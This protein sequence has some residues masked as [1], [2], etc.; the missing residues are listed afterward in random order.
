MNSVPGAAT[1]IAALSNVSVI[2]VDTLQ[3]GNIGS[4]ARALKN[5]GLGRLKLVNPP[6]VNEECR[7]MAGKAMDL[8]EG[9]EH[10][11]SLEDA[12]AGEAVVAATTSS[13][14]RRIRRV[15]LTPRQAAPILLGHAQ[16][17]R[18]AIVFGSE[19]SGLNEDQLA[20]C[21]V[22]ITIPANP[23][24]PVLNLAQSV[25]LLAYELGSFVQETVDPPLPAA[26]QSARQE[27]FEQIRRT[28]IEIG[29][30]SASNPEPVLRSI[31]AILDQPGLTP[32]DV[33]IIRGIMSQM[34]WYVKDGWR[35]GPEGVRK[36]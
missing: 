28:L 25:L 15:P 18:V 21:Q 13:R 10:F 6:P 30:L 34:D 4:A 14:D 19:R 35:L 23:E 7:R 26:S 33:R 11:P 29:F 22:L 5:M 2:L 3:A 36:A 12:V 16:T 31:R 9:A 17:E 1:K 24:Y 8:I 27:M 20:Q 32:R